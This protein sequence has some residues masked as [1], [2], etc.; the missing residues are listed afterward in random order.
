MKSNKAV[1]LLNDPSSGLWSPFPSRGEGNGVRGFT[2][3]ELL[4]VVLIIGILA[5]VAV[6][7]YQKA[8]EKA[9]MVGAINILKVIRDAHIRYYLANGDYVNSSDLAKLDIEI[10]G[11]PACY[12]SKR[13]Q[14]QY[15]VYSPSSDYLALASRINSSLV[16]NYGNVAYSMYILKRVPERI[17]CLIINEDIATEVQKKLCAQVNEKGTL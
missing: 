15:F 8:V 17:N 16:C 11:T 1:V 12:D 6:P 4:V 7:Q 10:P 13:T 3:I 14:T 9:R 2:L 5:A